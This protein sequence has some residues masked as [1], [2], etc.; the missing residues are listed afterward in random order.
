V[1]LRDKGMSYPAIAKN[2]KTM[3]YSPKTK[4]KDT[5]H[6]STVANYYREGKE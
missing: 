5:F 2:L 3:G 4:G 1:D 6:H